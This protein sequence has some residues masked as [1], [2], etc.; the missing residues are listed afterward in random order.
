MLLN[1]TDDKMCQLNILLMHYEKKDT[2]EKNGCD[3]LQ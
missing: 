1:Y 3:C 2:K